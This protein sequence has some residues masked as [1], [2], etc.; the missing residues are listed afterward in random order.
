MMEGRGRLFIVDFSLFMA[1]SCWGLCEKRF[2]KY[3][4]DV[5]NNRFK[6]IL[7]IIFCFGNKISFLIHIRDLVVV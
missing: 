6:T 1:E 7:C 2:D 5:Y 4:C 3:R